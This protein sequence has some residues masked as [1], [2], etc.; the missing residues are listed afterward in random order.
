M[1]TLE[2]RGSATEDEVDM[3]RD[4]GVLEVLPT[5]I[6]ED[7]VLPAQE[8]AVAE[9]HAIAVDAQREGLTDR[10][11]GVLERQV[12]GREVVR[13]DDRRRRAERP[14]RL[15]VDARQVRVKVV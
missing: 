7:R 9:H 14:D 11:R 2:V 6:E 15:A 5:A 10:S 12:L 4:E 13:V 1:A 3:A 8:P